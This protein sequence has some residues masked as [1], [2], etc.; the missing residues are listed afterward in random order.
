VENVLDI[1]RNGIDSALRGLG[2]GSVGELC[3]DD[4]VVPDGFV[5][6]LGA[7]GD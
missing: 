5:R 4:V 6:R 7:P 2:R 1:L 3:A